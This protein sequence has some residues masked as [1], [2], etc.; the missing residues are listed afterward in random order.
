M[1][2]KPVTQKTLCYIAHPNISPPGAC[3]WKIALNYKV[4]QRKT[5]KFT[6]NRQGGGYYKARP[7]DFKM[8]ISLCR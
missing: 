2:P 8:Q 7:I 3:T 5:G 6:S 4:K 1:P